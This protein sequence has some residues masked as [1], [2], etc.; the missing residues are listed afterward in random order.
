MRKLDMVDMNSLNSIAGMLN[1]MGQYKQADVLR[2]IQAKAT[3]MLEDTDLK[4]ITVYKTVNVT[5]PRNVLVQIPSFIAGAT[6]HLKH[7][8]KLEV[9]YN[10][11][12]QEVTIRPAVR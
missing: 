4:N 1:L 2:C 12:T 9:L 5:N 3:R 11:A 10:E 8:D 7:G 6:W